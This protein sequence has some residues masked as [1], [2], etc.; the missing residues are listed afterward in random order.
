MERLL[1]E[2]TKK[3]MFMKSIKNLKHRAIYGKNPLI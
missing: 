1:G 2:K 3:I